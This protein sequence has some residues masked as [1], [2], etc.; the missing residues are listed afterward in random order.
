MKVPKEI[1]LNP[2]KISV[3]Q[4]ICDFISQKFSRLDKE[5]KLSDNLSRDWNLDSLDILEL[6]ASLI[7]CLR[8]NFT[9]FYKN[10][11]KNF[12]DLVVGDI[13][14]LATIC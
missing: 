9:D 12:N 14:E 6:E 1:T 11:K 13:V 8:E 7:G 10:S 5:I 3:F 4:V 2:E